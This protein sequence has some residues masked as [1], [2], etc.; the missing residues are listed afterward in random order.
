MASSII[1]EQFRIHNADK[2]LRSFDATNS[3]TNSNNMYFF[4]GRHRSW[5]S[6]YAAN[7]NYGTTNTPVLDE[8]NVPTP[9]DNGDFSNEVYD[10]ILSLKKIG[11]PNV[12]KVVRR[13][14]WQQG[15]KYTM[16][17]PDYNTQN[18]TATGTSNLYDSEFYVMNT[19]TYEV[20]KVLNNGVTPSNPT[21]TATGSTAPTAAAA[22]SN[23]I[24]DFTSTDGYVYQYLYKLETNDVLFFTTTDFIP[25][26][27]TSYAGTVINGAIDIAL[28]KSSG[29]GLPVAQSLYFKIHGDGD[30]DTNGYAVLKLSTD[31]GGTAIS[32]EITTRGR[33]YTYG[34]VDLSPSATYYASENDLRAGTSPLTLPSSGY[35]SPSIELVMPPQGGH[36]SNISHELGAKRVMLNTRMVYGNRSTAADKTTDFY[37]DQDFRRIGILKDPNNVT[38][39]QLTTE[40]ASGTHS[41]IIDT[42]TGSG[43]FSRDEV[44]TQS[45]TVTRGTQTLT[46]TAKGRVVDY[47]QYDTS[48]NLAILRYTQAPNDLELRDSDGS[49]WPFYT[50]ATGGGAV[51]NIIGVD[52]GSDRP[53]NRGSQGVIENQ[54]VFVNG[55]CEPE[56]EKYTGEI[57]YVEN[58]RVIT[59]AADQIEDVKLVIE[60]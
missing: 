2:F 50:A 26:K 46:V 16:Y 19:D 43:I 54:G 48:S 12:R 18:Q 17:R 44:I 55:I 28:L 6:A 7:S 33:N 42:S 30:D 41:I 31:A 10:D 11:Y 3:G 45:Y 36:G 51:N 4:I 39:S 53:I 34:V 23:N 22:D 13:Y 32:A 25:V 60:F 1:T 24:V 38:G 49:I 15:K 57:I 14:N 5:Y 20:F 47:N 35:S 56:Y 29:S 59:R 27:E 9:Y 58:R 21:G 52:S 40:T 8:G 37:V